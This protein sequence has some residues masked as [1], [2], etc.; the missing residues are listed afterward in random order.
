MLRNYTVISRSVFTEACSPTNF[1]TTK[2]KFQGKTVITHEARQPSQTEVRMKPEPV[3]IL[4]L[5]KI[6]Y[7][8]PCV[9][10]PTT[11]YR[12]R[13]KTPQCAP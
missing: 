7:K 9:A 4:R 5:V 1:F 3:V 2:R 12:R 13:R 11:G 10:S 8:L 6:P